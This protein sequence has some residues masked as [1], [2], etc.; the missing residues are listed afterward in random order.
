MFVN[1][2]GKHFNAGQLQPKLSLEQS[3]NN[4]LTLT[5]TNLIFIAVISALISSIADV[6]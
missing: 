5:D 4:A 1:N 3:D 2:K 6:L